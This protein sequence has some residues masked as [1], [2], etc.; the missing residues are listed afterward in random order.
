MPEGRLQVRAVQLDSQGSELL[1]FAESAGLER[2]LIPFNVPGD[3]EGVALSVAEPVDDGLAQ[4]PILVDG[5]PEGLSFTP[6]ALQVLSLSHHQ[7]LLA[8][9]KDIGPSMLPLL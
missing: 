4:A 8:G 6:V 5:L 9:G 2:F 3:V 7:R 1:G